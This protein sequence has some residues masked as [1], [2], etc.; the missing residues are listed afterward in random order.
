MGT[1][2]QE[3]HNLPYMDGS[4]ECIPGRGSGQ[5]FFQDFFSPQTPPLHLPGYTT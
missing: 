4:H 2:E 1:Q 5:L 3:K